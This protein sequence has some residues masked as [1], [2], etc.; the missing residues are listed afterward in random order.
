MGTIKLKI[1]IRGVKSLNGNILF[2]IINKVANTHYIFKWS[3][4]LV[5]KIVNIKAE[6][7]NIALAIVRLS[8]AEICYFFIRIGLI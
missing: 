1:P 4:D 8:N 2:T 5:E 3:K 7:A 6:N